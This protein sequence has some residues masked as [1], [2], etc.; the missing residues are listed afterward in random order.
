[1]TIHHEL[2]PF[3]SVCYDPDGLHLKAA[4]GS[5]ADLAKIAPITLTF[6]MKYDCGDYGG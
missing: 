6:P 3:W 5:P 4:R 2:D 1:V